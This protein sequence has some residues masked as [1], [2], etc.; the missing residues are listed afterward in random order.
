MDD[1][2]ERN[3]LKFGFFCTHTHTNEEA[4]ADYDF[5]FSMGGC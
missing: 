5:N 4:T 1:G 2:K 3:E